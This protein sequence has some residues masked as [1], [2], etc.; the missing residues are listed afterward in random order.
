MRRSHVSFER[1]HFERSKTLDE[2]SSS[3]AR[4]YLIK[5]IS[6]DESLKEESEVETEEDKNSS[7][8]GTTNPRFIFLSIA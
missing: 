6:D 8:S 3:V 5:A 7:N 4:N 2:R 1:R